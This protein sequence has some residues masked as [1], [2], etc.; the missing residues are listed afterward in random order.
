LFSLHSRLSPQYGLSKTLSQVNLGHAC[1]P[2]N[3]FYS[4]FPSN[5]LC[6]GGFFHTKALNLSSNYFQILTLASWR[7]P[8]HRLKERSTGRGTSDFFRNV[9]LD[10][11]VFKIFHSC[12]SL[13]KY[14]P[15][16]QKSATVIHS[17]ALISIFSF[18]VSLRRAVNIGI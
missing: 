2:V 7:T 16:I 3:A 9:E 1:L 4:C 14:L 12:L 10:C 6:R 15:L 13:Q 11:S 8:S 18:T 5:C 17:K